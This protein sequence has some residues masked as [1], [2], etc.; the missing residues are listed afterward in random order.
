MST[1]LSVPHSSVSSAKTRRVVL[2]VLHHLAVIFFCFIF[3][4]PLAGLVAT[5]LKT[6]KQIQNFASFWEL[7]WPN[8]VRWHNYVEV[9]QLV[10]F[11]R[12]IMNSFYVS[13]M[14]IVGTVVSCSCVAYAFSRLRWPGRDVFFA[15]LL[16]T[17]MLPTQVTLVPTFLIF[18]ELGWV[19]SFKPLWFPTF[20]GTAFFIFLLRQFFLTIPR[21]LEEAAEIDGC[22][23][24]RIFWQI[25]LPLLKPSLLAV[26]I[27]QF[28]G[29]WND[30]VGPL[31]YL[32]RPDILTLSVGVQ[33]FRSLHGSQWALLLAAST[34]MTIPV[35]ILFFMAQRYFIEGITLTGMKG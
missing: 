18:S 14:A 26:V 23:Y 16:A 10:P 3:T 12:Y 6:D 20:F 5:S 25:L 32:N 1:S 4:V 9:F 21:D 27:F 19:N 29:S 15:I 17:M 34:M 33:A 31:V 30:F 22:G 7:F 2:R 11:A 8:P 35:L 28:L 24:G 13:F